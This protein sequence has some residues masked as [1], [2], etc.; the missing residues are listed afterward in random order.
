[1]ATR[2]ERRPH[3]SKGKRRGQRTSK[4]PDQS[5]QGPGDPVQFAYERGVHLVVEKTPGGE[6]W[7]AYSPRSGRLIGVYYPDAGRVVVRGHGHR[8]RDWRLAVQAMADAL[9]AEEG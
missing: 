2:T 7:S 1:M 5:R 8:L 4:R 6:A 3:R 9:A